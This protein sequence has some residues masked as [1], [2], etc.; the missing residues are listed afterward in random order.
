MA[1]PAAVPERLGGAPRADTLAVVPMAAAGGV[2]GLMYVLAGVPSAAVWPWGYTVFAAA[3]L[4]AYRRRGW[5]RALDLQLALSLVIPWLLMLDLGGF[6]ISGAVMIWSLIAPVGALLAYGVRRAAGWFAAYAALALVAALLEGHLDEAAV[7]LGWVATFFFMDVIGVTLVAWVVTA[8]YASQRA[9]LIAAE[10]A[11]RLQAEEATRAKSEFLANMSHEIRTPMNAVIGMSSLLATTDLDAEQR[12]YLT[13]VQTSA[14]VLLATINDVLDFSKIEAGRMEVVHAP[15]VVRGVVE[16]AVDVVAP[17]ASQKRLELVYDMGAD[18]PAVVL[19]DGHRLG[20]V[21]VNLLTNAVKFTDAGEVRLLVSTV[22]ADDGTRVRFEVQDTGIGIPPEARDRLFR[23]FS[24]VDGTSSRRFGGTGLGLAISQRITA[25]LG[26]LIEVESDPGHGSRFWFTI[27]AEAGSA[28]AAPGDDGPDALRGRTVLV[29]EPNRTGLRLLEGLL[30][31]WGA[32]LV[33]AE[34]VPGALAALAGLHEVSSAGPLVDL[35]VLDHRVTDAA[36]LWRRLETGSGLVPPVV[37]LAPLGTD[38]PQS[39][40]GRRPAGSVAKPVKRSALLA[41]VTAQVGGASAPRPAPPVPVLDPGFG[42]AHPLRILVAEDNPT[43]QRLMTRFLERLGY[44][45]TVV[46]DGAAAVEATAGGSEDVV[47][48]DIQMPVLD[49]FEATR[50]IRARDGRQPWIV[51]VTANATDEDRKACVAAGMDD[52]LAK[53]VRPE[54]LVSAL[55]TAYERF[56]AP[57]G[58][59]RAAARTSGADGPALPVA[60]TAAP[61]LDTSAL[62]QLVELTGDRDFVASL[63]ADF[64]GQLAA[65]MADI[66]AG[67]PA[68]PALVHRQAHSLKSSAAQLGAR[69]LA[70]QSAR[71]ERAA[72]ENATGELDAQLPELEDLA[73][74]TVEALEALDGW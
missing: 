12:E 10:R 23:S 40:G 54:E 30:R 61:L 47:L 5:T 43:N 53:P 70:E 34:D 68:D 9:Q 11:A 1:E 27:P 60:A 17:L 4:W 26:G 2:W 71:V 66:R 64:P 46:G 15:V 13:S 14:E 49:G 35:V 52:H 28:P 48:M 56:A 24:Q 63:L 73:R 25:M 37:L 6:R 59:A 72:R 65:M 74:R 69:A 57:V 3:N 36:E 38:L 32:H 18:V 50:R 39:M 67:R 29:V 51:A 20:Q 22:A 42:A 31:S 19:S 62:D 41:A 44:Q 58:A 21:L 16:S 45:P 33:S 8:R 7:S 55:R